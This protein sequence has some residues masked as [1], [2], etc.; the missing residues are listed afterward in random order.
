MA[1]A[2]LNELR[3]WQLDQEDQDIRGWELKEQTGHTIGTIDDLIVDTNTHMVDG[4]LLKDGTEIPIRNIRIGKDYVYR[5]EAERFVGGT[6]PVAGEQELYKPEEP[7][8]RLVRF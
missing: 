7:R 1:R 2:R 6:Q 8:I 5:V 3:D 4:V